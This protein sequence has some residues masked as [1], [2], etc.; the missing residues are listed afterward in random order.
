MKCS[1]HLKVLMCSLAKD[2]LDRPDSQSF[3]LQRMITSRTCH[4][5]AKVPNIFFFSPTSFLTV[6]MSE[7]DKLCLYFYFYLLSLILFPFDKKPRA[8]RML[9]STAQDFGG[10]KYNAESCLEDGF[11]INIIETF[12]RALVF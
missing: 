9:E 12:K 3:L 2:Q 10:S 7:I 11:S 4:L 8:E 6:I 5:L 1:N